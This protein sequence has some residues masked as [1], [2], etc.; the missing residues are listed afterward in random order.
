MYNV[1]FISLEAP[2]TY[3]FDHMLCVSCMSYIITLTCGQSQPRKT[4]QA[5][6]SKWKEGVVVD[7]DRQG[8][9]VR[10]DPRVRTLRVLPEPDIRHFQ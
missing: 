9:D 3:E 6:Y 8:E 10:A 4:H 7:V 5:V 2:F 1:K